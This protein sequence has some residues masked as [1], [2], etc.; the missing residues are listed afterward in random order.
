VAEEPVQD[1]D[2]PPGRGRQPVQGVVQRINLLAGD[3][4]PQA[5]I[6]DPVEGAEQLETALVAPEP[7]EQ[8]QHPAGLGE[9]QRRP[10]PRGRRRQ[11][12]IER[13]V[14]AVVDQR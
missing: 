14:A 2:P 3:D 7:A 5:R 12:G 4:Q 13:R 10:A 9:A 11:P 6:V 1:H 8:E